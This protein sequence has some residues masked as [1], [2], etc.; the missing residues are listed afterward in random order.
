MFLGPVAVQAADPY[1][2]PETLAEE[3]KENQTNTLQ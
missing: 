3:H 1:Y 2:H